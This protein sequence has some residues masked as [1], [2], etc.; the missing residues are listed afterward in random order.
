M[1]T[2]EEEEDWEQDIADH[3]KTKQLIKHSNLALEPFF[4]DYDSSGDEDLAVKYL[5]KNGNGAVMT[6]NEIDP[7]KKEES[8]KTKCEDLAGLK[9][10]DNIDITDNNKNTNICDDERPPHIARNNS[11]TF[12]I[13]NIHDN[14]TL[15][16]FEDDIVILQDADQFSDDESFVSA[17]SWSQDI[18]FDKSILSDAGANDYEFIKCSETEDL[19]HDIVYNKIAPMKLLVGRR[20]EIIILSDVTFPNDFTILPVQDVDKVESMRQMLM[21]CSPK[22]VRVPR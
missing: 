17:M 1:D 2:N 20:Y 8:S 9:G 18:N 11:S 12:H 16:R 6:T 14:D 4:D 15:Q 10:V 7:D 13:D 21:N 3:I 5:D 19:K 22:P